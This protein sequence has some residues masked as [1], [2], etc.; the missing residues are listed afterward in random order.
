MVSDEPLYPSPSIPRVNT[1]L[2]R[3]Q[4]QSWERFSCRRARRGAG[5][6]S[7]IRGT[8]HRHDGPSSPPGTVASGP[9][10]CRQPGRIHQSAARLV[11]LIIGF[12]AE[13]GLQFSR[14]L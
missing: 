3:T 4:R 5:E 8:Q 12:T 9:P 11:P 10:R 14:E 1:G 13:D 7:L 6:G 2:G